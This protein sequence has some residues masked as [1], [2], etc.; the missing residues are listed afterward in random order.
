M[1]K[2]SVILSLPLTLST[3]SVRLSNSLLMESSW[4]PV[5]GP[6]RSQCLSV[7]PSRP[8]FFRSHGC[9]LELTTDMKSEPRCQRD[10]TPT[11]LPPPGANGNNAPG[12]VKAES[13]NCGA[14]HT[15]L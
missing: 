11:T 5:T 13:S 8:L 14:T 15:P 6:R 9:Q 3:S 12:G 4:R 2:A 7:P 10:H 1:A